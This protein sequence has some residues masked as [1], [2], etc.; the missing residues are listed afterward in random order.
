M[1]SSQE[2]PRQSTR[3]T[4]ESL[5]IAGPSSAPANQRF[6][7]RTPGCYLVKATRV[8]PAR[9]P[10]V[11]S[12]GSRQKFLH[13]AA[14]RRERPPVRIK[15]G[16]RTT[17]CL[18]VA[19]YTPPQWQEIILSSLRRNEAP[20]RRRRSRARNC[21]DPNFLLTGAQR[22]QARVTTLLGHLSWWTAAEMKDHTARLLN[23]GFRRALCCAGHGERW[24]RT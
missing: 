2:H 15:L 10:R 9:L 5:S 8:R 20:A 17:T 11:I 7:P 6:P 4:S 14:G 13:P 3:T 16:P 19:H 1:T 12:H 22:Y 18:R 24:T 23:F 21:A